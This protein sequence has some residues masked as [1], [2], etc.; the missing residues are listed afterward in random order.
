M[1]LQ[2]WREGILAGHRSFLSDSIRYMSARNFVRFLGRET[3]VDQW[4]LIRRHVPPELVHEAAPLDALWS[5]HRSGTFNLR[6]ESALARW[7]GRRRALFDQVVREPGISIYRAAKQAHMPY[8]RAYDHVQA[9]SRQ[10][11]IR[12]RVGNG[13]R[14]QTR[15]YSF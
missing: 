7:P 13:P 14:K 8:R 2:R 9:L 11:L 10:G 5:W 15:L 6:P 1:P 12:T 3:F 4:P